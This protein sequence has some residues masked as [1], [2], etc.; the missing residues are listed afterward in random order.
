M[1][2]I[3]AQL[4]GIGLT[5]GDRFDLAESEKRFP[6]GAHYRIEVP[7]IQNPIAAAALVKAAGVYGISINRITETR[8]IMRLTDEE[9]AEMA[10]IAREAR[11]E[12]FLSVGPRAP[13]DTSAQAHTGTGEA[14]RIGYRLRGTD[15]LARAVADVLRATD[16]G[17]RGILVYDEGCL[18]TLN[19]LRKIEFIPKDTRF[20]LSAHCGHGNAAS[21]KLLHSIGADSINV[22]RDLQIPMMASIRAVCDV[23]LDIHVDNPKSTGG[24]IRTYEAPDIVRCAAPVYLKTGASVF[25]THAWPTTEKDAELCA[26]QASL[27]EQA[28]RK[29]FP[30]AVQSKPGAIDLAI[31]V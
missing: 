1:K 5:E 10:H 29:F 31:P 12:L 14:A 25:G 3:K 18:W 27:A 22:V 2:E 30:E 6:D 23:H 26:K 19:E 15:Q 20:K 21:I 13:Y 28:V 11:A 24:F 16:L 7:G 8:G 4:K 17:V 9:I